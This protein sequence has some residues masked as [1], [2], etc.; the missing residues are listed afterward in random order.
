MFRLNI[1]SFNFKKY[2][3]FILFTIDICFI[4]A[5]IFFSFWL[6][7]N[8]FVNLY[9]NYVYS[10]FINSAWIIVVIF[11]LT[12]HYKSL[13]RY[14]GSPDLYRISLRSLFSIILLSILTLIFKFQIPPLKV[15]FLIWLLLVASTSLLRFTLRDILFKFLSIKNKNKPKVAIYGAGEAGAQLLRAL[16]FSGKSEVVFFIDDDPIMSSRE[17]NGL[18]IYTPNK[19]HKLSPKIDQILFAI[20]SLSSKQKSKKLEKIQ[21]YGIP[22]FL[23]PSIE[24]LI[25]GKSRIDYLKPVK[26]EDLLG[27]DIVP[28]NKSL[29]RKGIKNKVVF[30]SGAGGSI[31]SELCKQ[32]LKFA[33]SKLILFDQSELNL[34]NLS[35]ELETFNK[36][37]IEIILLLGSTTDLKLINNIFKSNKI[38]IIFHAAAYKHVPLVEINPIEGIKN[39]VISIKN[40]CESAKINNIQKVILIS[41]DKAV[42]PSNIMGASKRLSELIVQAYAYEEKLKED[43]NNFIYF[44]M[45][46]FGNVL[47]SSGSVVPLFQEQISK[48]GPITITH[49]SV[50]RYF[51]TITEAAQLVLQ[52]AFLSKGGDLFLLDMGKPEKIL[53]LAK[54]MIALSSLTLKNKANPD[55]DIEIKTTGLRPGEKL[56][57]EL[58]ID[59]NAKKTSHELIFRANEKFLLPELLWPIIDKLL[60]CLDN[61]DLEESLNILSELVPEWERSEI[62]S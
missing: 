41:T 16:R 9:G 10:F 15:L 12:G 40:I 26:I 53:N 55:G 33:P 11:Y 39:N 61:N 36:D 38:D 17:L 31:G 2:N 45:V 7:N 60:K 56:Y 51:M 8:Q 6:S 43:K 28:P 25:S 23:I 24:E 5:S 13:T 35:R 50:V 19:L 57:E 49:E 27:R 21:K 20:P 29:L 44:S 1:N 62:N 54:K 32:I 48:G 4:Y 59:G 30:I 42:R 3:K 18:N 47:G 37:N 34:Y 46:R 14:V 58:L 22:T 52:A